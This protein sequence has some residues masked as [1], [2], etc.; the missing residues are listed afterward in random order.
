LL[1][2]LAPFA[3]LH[4]RASAPPPNVS[5]SATPAP[6]NIL[7]FNSSLAF[8]LDGT[9]S[10]GRSKAGQIVPAHLAK[11]LV[12]GGMTVAPAGTPI[13]IKVVDASPASNPDIYGYVDIFARPLQLPDGRQI[14]LRPPATHLN[15]NVTAGH[16]STSDVENTIGDI[17]A[18]TLLYHIFRKGRNFTLEPGATIWLHT[19]VTL[20]AL[21]NGTVAI[22][23][24]AP[25]IIDQETPISSFRAAPMVTV[26]PSYRPPLPTPDDHI[27]P[28][29]NPTF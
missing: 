26:D 14:P 1:A 3:P 5:A 12:V 21:K 25:L 6:P 24:P 22:E 28:A 8:I 7:P 29:P 2:A 27:T 15:V 20:V 18:P 10:S 13:Q 11:P 19:E 4:A 9:I 16:N 23:T 17:F